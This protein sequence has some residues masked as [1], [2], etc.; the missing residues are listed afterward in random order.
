MPY[1]ETTKGHAECAKCGGWQILDKTPRKA[2]G[3]PKGPLVYVDCDH[4]GGRGEVPLTTA[5]TLKPNNP[6]NRPAV[7]QRTAGVVVDDDV[8]MPGESQG[9]PQPP[10][11]EGWPM[12]QQKGN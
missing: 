7:R 12:F 5:V 8:P 4:C 6:W 9:W 1:F 10:K 3:W 2:D 11:A